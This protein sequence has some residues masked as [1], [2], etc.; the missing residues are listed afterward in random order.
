MDWSFM[1]HVGDVHTTFSWGRCMVWSYKGFVEDIMKLPKY[2]IFPSPIVLNALLFMVKMFLT[3]DTLRHSLSSIAASVYFFLAF[4]LQ[5]ICII[6]QCTFAQSCLKIAY[7]CVRKRLSSLDC[8]PTLMVPLRYVHA[9]N[10]F[11]LIW[12]WRQWL[13]PWIGPTLMVLFESLQLI[14]SL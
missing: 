2:F 7:D 10:G 1:F 12:L 14:F 8:I 5:P 11:R 4:T 3:S 9:E 13:L 6:F